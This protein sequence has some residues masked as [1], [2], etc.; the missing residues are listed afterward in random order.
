M[1]LRDF[2][3]SLRAKRSNPELFAEQRGLLR[4]ARNDGVSG[5]GSAA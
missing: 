1:M 5:V 2:L 3:P 4:C